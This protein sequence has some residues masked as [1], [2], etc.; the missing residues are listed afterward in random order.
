MKE[1]TIE[2]QRL[3]MEERGMTEDQ[4]ET[5]MAFTKKYF[6]AFMIFGVLLGTLIFGCIASL[7]G[8]AIAKKKP[9]NPMN[10]GG[11]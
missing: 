5:A 8:A 10:Q 4:I 1:K 2:M 6:T 7:I 11:L 9:I 3:K